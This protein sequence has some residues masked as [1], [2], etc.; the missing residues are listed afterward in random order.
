MLVFKGRS[1][2][3]RRLFEIGEDSLTVVKEEEK[4]SRNR[5]KRMGKE[6]TKGKEKI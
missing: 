5:N 3:R 4:R 6:E 2:R 1:K